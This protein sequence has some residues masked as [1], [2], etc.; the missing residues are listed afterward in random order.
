MG[1]FVIA[2]LAIVAFLY[3]Q[4]QQL[5]SM[6]ASYQTPVAS[7]APVATVD[8]TANWK[9]Y[10]SSDQKYSF[11]YPDDNDWKVTEYSHPLGFWTQVMCQNCTNQTL[12]YFQITPFIYRSLA[13]FS[14]SS[15]AETLLDKSNIKF[16][17]LD[18]IQSLQIGK[19]S[20]TCR[21][22]FTVFQNQGYQLSECFKDD[23]PSIKTV[24]ELPRVNP[25][26]FSTF[27]F[28]Q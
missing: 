8:P 6:I 7:A 9:T 20:P 19:Q 10:T 3:Y 18:A 16:D 22:V 11:K 1:L 2:S 28:T 21:N 25:D 5:K 15:L 4:N 27:K 23:L 26:I 12:Y 24:N 17:N 13:E 14:S